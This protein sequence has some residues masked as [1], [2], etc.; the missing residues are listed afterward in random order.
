MYPGDCQ[1]VRIIPCFRLGIFSLN[2]HRFVL[3]LFLILLVKYYLCIFAC[4][5]FCG[6]TEF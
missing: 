1:F 5:K 2:S 6:I 3:N 4:S